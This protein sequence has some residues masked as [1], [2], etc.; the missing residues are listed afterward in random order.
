MENKKLIGICLGAILVGGSVAH[1]RNL[2]REVLARPVSCHVAEWSP[3]RPQRKR[4]GHSR[5][6]ATAPTQSVR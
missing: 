2:G 4:R 3:R 5:K 1:A 6:A